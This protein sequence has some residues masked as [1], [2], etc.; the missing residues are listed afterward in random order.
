MR[1]VLRPG[2][3]PAAPDHP[4]CPGGDAGRGAGPAAPGPG[5]AV[6]RGARG[7]PQGRRLVAG[8]LRGRPVLGAARA[9]RA[10]GVGAPPR[11]AGR[12]HP[13]R[14]G[15]PGRG[16]P[17]PGDRA[18]QPAGRRRALPAGAAWRAEPHAEGA[19]R[20]RSPVPGYRGRR[21]AVAGRGSGR[22]RV[23]GPG[24][25]GPGGAAGRA[26]RRGRHRPGARPGRL[27]RPV[28]RRRPGRHPRSPGLRMPKASRARAGEQS[29]LAQGTSG[30]ARHGGTEAAR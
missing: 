1:G 9:G 15:R 23:P 16:G 28:R 25:D 26:A 22:R 7:D 11:R 24:Q 18:G 5:R 27:G 13:C 10:A 21:R 20:S 29:S 6:H 30:W 8:D 3:R 19:D 17:A 12:D 2:Q 14:A 4:P